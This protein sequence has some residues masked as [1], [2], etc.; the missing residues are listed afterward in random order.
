MRVKILLDFAEGGGTLEYIKTS[1]PNN[2][3]SRNA[4]KSEIKVVNG[5]V[6]GE[7]NNGYEVIAMNGVNTIGSYSGSLINEQ[8]YNGYM[9]G[10]SGENG[11]NSIVLTIKGETLGHCG[12]IFDRVAGQYPHKYIHTYAGERTE[13]EN[14]SADPYIIDGLLGANDV[15][16]TLE[17]T[18]W[19][20][21]NYPM[22]LTFFEYLPSYEVFTDSDV[23]NI[24]TTIEATNDITTINYG[25][26]SNIGNIE[27][28][29]KTSVQGY[30]LLW[31]YA[32]MGYFNL[33]TFTLKIE[34]FNGE[35]SH[36][37]VSK[38]PYYSNNKTFSADLTDNIYTWN[39]LMC[40]PTAYTSQTTLYDVLFDL[41]D[42][43]I[44]R[45]SYNTFQKMATQKIVI[46]NN[47][48]NAEVVQDEVYLTEYLQNII[49]P[50]FSFGEES[51]IS[52]LN[53]ICVVAQLYCY[54]DENNILS[55][56][57]ARPKATQDEIDNRLIVEYGD[58]FSEV[59]STILVA[60]AYDNVIIK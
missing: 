10:L 42:T 36:H 18:D 50:A 56:T 60:N 33:S 20:R 3:A 41:L 21:P 17:F 4:Y 51:F 43:Y 16:Q 2:N 1:S 27:I 23:I 39:E 31:N 5:S 54:Y 44:P 38:T 13:Y 24:D 26:M 6:E 19:E 52:R 37:I 9:W 40:E 12:I 47:N 28:Y 7:I 32:K 29:D 8:R 35:V 14:T 49:I 55:F 53:K 45:E 58:Q 34:M 22:C 59:V 48:E 57:N 11:E 25:C 46:G 15:E 30:N